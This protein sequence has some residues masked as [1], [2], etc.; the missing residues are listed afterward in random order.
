MDAFAAEDIARRIHAG[1]RG[2][3]GRPLVEHLE[4]VA[5]AVPPP[6]R[7]TAWLHDALETTAVA[8]EELRAAGLDADELDA[9]AL[10][11]RMPMESYEL[12]TL[13]IA[14]AVDEAGSLARA[15]KLAAL[16]DH[17]A[18]DADSPAAPPYAWARRRI[19][20]AHARQAAPRALTG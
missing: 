1:Q 18:Y 10:L 13:R 14:Y 6:A 3:G 15:V 8:G 4:R 9:L 17:L 7:A 2:R 16:D 12:Y 11:A 20:V 19:A 5:A